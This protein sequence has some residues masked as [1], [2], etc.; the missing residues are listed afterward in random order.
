LQDLHNPLWLF[1]QLEKE[2]PGKDSTQWLSC[3]LISFF[4]PP[5]FY[6]TFYSNLKILN[7]GALDCSV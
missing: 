1:L 4:I 3:E 7:V 2:L 5:Y 6:I